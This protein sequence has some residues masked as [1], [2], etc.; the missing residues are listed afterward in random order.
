MKTINPC[1]LCGACCAY[2]RAS[3][4][5]AETD[6]CSTGTVPA[7]MTGKLNHLLVFMKGTDQPSPRCMGLL[8]I[9]GKK[10]RCR[11]YEHSST[12]CREFEPSW[13]SGQKNERCDKARAFWGL[14]P[15]T[16]EVWQPPSK[17]PKAA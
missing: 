14:N 11:I 8:G 9:I 7:E 5:W 15:L 10:V 4:Y 13:Q 3:F 17:F 1:L 16:P 12:V 6:A 2:Y